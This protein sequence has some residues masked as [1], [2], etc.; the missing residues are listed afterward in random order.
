MFGSRFSTRRWTQI[1]ALAMVAVAALV[2]SPAHSVPDYGG[3]QPA[4]GYGT[5][6]STFIGFTGTGKAK[7]RISVVNSS[8]TMGIKGVLVYGPTAPVA[9]S[10]PPRT[11]TTLYN[12]AQQYSWW[13]TKGGA[14][15]NG[16]GLTDDYIEPGE[17]VTNDTYVLTYNGAIDES[18][19]K[20]ALHVVYPFT[21]K[22][23]FALPGPRAD[24]KLLVTAAND[25]CVL[26]GSSLTF[27]Y[28]VT[29][30]G[31][32]GIHNL[33]VSDAYGDVVTGQSLAVGATLNLSRTVTINTAA[34]TVTNTVSA[35]GQSVVGNG[36]VA[37]NVTTEVQVVHP[38][39]VVSLTATPSPVGPDTPVTYTY[40]VLNTGDYALENVVVTDTTDSVTTTVATVAELAPGE[41]QSFTR[42]VESLEVTTT[43]VANASGS[44][45]CSGT[46]VS[47]T[48]A[49]FTVPRKN[50]K[51]TLD[52][53]L[54]SGAAYCGETVN[55]SF[56][57]HNTGDVDLN[58]VK[59]TFLADGYVKNIGTLAAGADSAVFSH[60][61]VVPENYSGPYTILV[62]VTAKDPNGVAVSP[63]T[64]SSVVLDVACGKIKGTISCSGADGDPIEGALVELLDGTT[65]VATTTT[66]ASGQYEFGDAEAGDYRIRVSADEYITATSALFHFA[67]TA[68]DAIPPLSTLD[69]L[70]ISWQAKLRFSGKVFFSDQKR[71]WDA[72]RAVVGVT[73]NQSDL[74][75]GAYKGNRSYAYV[76]TIPSFPE[77]G[78]FGGA[79]EPK[80]WVIM[81][82]PLVPENQWNN[83]NLTNLVGVEAGIDTGM[84]R[85]PSY[86]TFRLLFSQPF[87]GP[88]TAK[89]Y[90]VDGMNLTP[91]YTAPGTPSW[92]SLSPVLWAGSGPGPAHSGDVP[93]GWMARTR[94]TFYQVVNKST[95]V[96][97]LG[98]FKNACG[99][100][101]N[102]RCHPDT[103]KSP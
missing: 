48:P 88:G 98:F 56:Q 9:I 12:A 45:A 43:S 44:D 80:L 20:F 11:N 47:A 14:D 66:N 97:A 93:T 15:N 19:L 27:S 77:L 18:Q 102:F 38:G 74:Y 30:T 69:P 83:A 40:T 89:N 73:L 28:Q 64:A 59:V 82:D 71:F 78:H 65:V 84:S 62:K 100:K 103:G 76:G 101:F 2:A 7:Y 75:N 5:V 68:L 1:L 23:F 87:E 70:P 81:T 8:A 35:L 21:G 6:T 31:N 32:T 79:G 58:T 96:T 61:I 33:T 55:V 63:T 85:A 95:A 86:Y 53:N 91:L 72:G 39:L 49:T 37:D 90:T 42:T 57:V 4:N 36:F 16:N 25:P 34:I 60:P 17:S 50:P 26:D 92:Q 51:L 24:C 52:L 54:D 29:N 46:T 22:T 99:E 41:Q 3:L 13:D 10:I 67:H 94:L